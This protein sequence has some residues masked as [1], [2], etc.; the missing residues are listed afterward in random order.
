MYA[1]NVGV[2]HF[3]ALHLLR[4]YFLLLFVLGYSVLGAQGG[5]H[6]KRA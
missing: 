5:R 4:A 6:A 2:K 3:A 1:L